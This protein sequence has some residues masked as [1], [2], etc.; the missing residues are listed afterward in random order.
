MAARSASG[1]L[2]LAAALVCAAA[3]AWLPVPALP[4]LALASAGLVG[5]GPRVALA[6][7]AA[8]LAL[9]ASAGTVPDPAG[10]APETVAGLA[11]LV[12][13]YG[14]EGAAAALSTHPLRAVAAIAEGP[15][16]GG[17]AVGV[18]LQT[19]AAVAVGAALPRVRPSAWRVLAGVAAGWLAA[20][21]LVAA[22][23]RLG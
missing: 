4:L 17:I 9:G 13:V 19:G 1:H 5:A 16:W 2:V 20:G 18:A 6:V 22:A 10:V 7:S 14:P 23:L 8:G 3:S 21:V 11:R 15:V 12:E